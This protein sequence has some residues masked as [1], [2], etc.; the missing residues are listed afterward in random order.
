MCTAEQKKE[1]KKHLDYIKQKRPKEWDDLIGKFDP[2]KD[3]LEK[4][5][6]SVPE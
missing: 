6:A 3:N 1:I 5:L 4:F 2:K